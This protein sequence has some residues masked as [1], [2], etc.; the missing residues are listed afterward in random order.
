VH[1]IR[2]LVGWFAFSPA[3]ANCTIMLSQNR[4]PDL[5]QHILTFLHPIFTVWSD[6][7]STGGDALT[8]LHIHFQNNFDDVAG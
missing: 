1:S 7:L 3:M 5:N 8:Q 4:F 2:W 6:I